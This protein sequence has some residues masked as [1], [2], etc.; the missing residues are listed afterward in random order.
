MNLV[1]FWYCYCSVVGF[2]LTIKPLFYI[3]KGC[4]QLGNKGEGELFLLYLMI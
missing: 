2:I 3:G 4:S 1:E